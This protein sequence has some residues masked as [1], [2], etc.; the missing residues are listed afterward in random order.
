MWMFICWF[1]S[2][3][4]SVLSEFK[5]PE[6]V[7]EPAVEES[8]LKKT[9][10]RLFEVEKIYLDP[11]FKLSD[12]A[13]MAHT[14]RT[15]ISA[16]FNADNGTSFFEYV[17]RWRVDRAARLLCESDMKVK[18]VATQSGFSSLTTFHRVFLSFM[19]CTP[20]EY[21]ADKAIL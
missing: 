20:A 3:H 17:N 7:V 15:Y 12:V 5:E 21:R 11:K 8:P 9:I 19:K 4:E 14:N 6:P 1:I 18:D 2:R 13:R 10:T 16:Y